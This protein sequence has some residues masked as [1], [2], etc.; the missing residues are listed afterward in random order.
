MSKDE[1]PECPE[2]H[3]EMVRKMRNVTIGEKHHQPKQYGSRP[4]VR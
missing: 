4:R 2:G 3:G 1:N